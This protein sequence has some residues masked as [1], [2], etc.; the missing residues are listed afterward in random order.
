MKTYVL[1]IISAFVI[2]LGSCTKD[3]GSDANVSQTSLSS[4]AVTQD[5]FVVVRTSHEN[6]G[7]WNI[8]MNDIA[9][10]AYANGSKSFPANSMIVKEKRNSSGMITGYASMYRS[11]GD[12]NS[13]NGWVWNEYNKEGHIIYDASRK[14]NSCQSCHIQ[15]NVAIH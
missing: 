13:S 12:P 10:S 4:M 1:L 8:K 3:A 7:I 2:S 11:T 15:N 9:A 14:G 6:N 5:G